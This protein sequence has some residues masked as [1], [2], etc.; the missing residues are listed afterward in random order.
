[1]KKGRGGEKEHKAPTYLIETTQRTEK[2]S[3]LIVFIL[4]NEVVFWLADLQY[5]PLASR[6]GFESFVTSDRRHK[7]YTTKKHAYR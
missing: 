3:A 7:H 2:G 1:M 5:I 6:T 4:A